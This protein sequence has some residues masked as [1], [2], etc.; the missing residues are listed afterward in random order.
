MENDPAKHLKVRYSIESYEK[1]LVT[2]EDMHNSHEKMSKSH[3][4]MSKR[5]MRLEKDRL[6]D[7]SRD[8]AA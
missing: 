2:V 8:K 1:L 6:N 7:D 4:E 5:L 3:E